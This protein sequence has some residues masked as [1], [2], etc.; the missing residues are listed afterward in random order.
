MSPITGRPKAEN[1]KC[2]D[3]KVRIDEITNE[4][5]QSYCEANGIKRAEA[6]RQG[7]AMLLE[8]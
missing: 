4:K 6:I 8:K 5:L 1:P 3:I 7:I 2:I